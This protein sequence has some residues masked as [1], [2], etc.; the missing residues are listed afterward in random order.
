R[1]CR[2]VGLGA[3]HRRA[4]TPVDPANLGTGGGIMSEASEPVPMLV[5]GA[6]RV[7]QLC[8][9][10]EAAWKAAGSA[11]QRPR[12]EDYLVEAPEPEHPALLREL[13]VLEVEQRC[14]AG[15]TLRLEEY[16]ARFPTLDLKWLAGA[17][18]AT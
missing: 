4:Q 16:Q 9:R 18:C 3:A 7:D 13:I 2:S 8:D 12:I 10:F 6:R 11:D 14:R 17:M 15:E 5:A 1:T